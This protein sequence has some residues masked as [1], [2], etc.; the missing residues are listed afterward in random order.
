L[1]SRTPRRFSRK[2]SLV[3]SAIDIIVLCV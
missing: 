1:E 2:S 3:A